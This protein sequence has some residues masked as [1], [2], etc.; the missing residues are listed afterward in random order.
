MIF[1]ILGLLLMF[2]SLSMLPPIIVSLIYQDLS[3]EPFIIGFL[4]VLLLGLILW[5]P[6]RK[7]Q[8]DLRIRDGFLI[9][10]LIWTV[11]GI[12][13]GVP[14]MLS[15]TPY[16]SFTDAVF[17]A[18]S[19]I[20]TTGATVMSDL[21]NLPQ[22]ILYYRQ[23]LQWL[24]GMGFIVLALAVLPLLG[25]G[26]MQ[27]YRAEVPGPM[28]ETKLTPR[29]TDTA[30]ALWGIYLGITVACIIAYWLA[31][32][33]LFDAIGHAFS[34][35]ATGGFS[36]H[37]QSFAYFNSPLIEVIGIFFM[38]I[39]GINFAVHFAALTKRNL[40]IYFLDSEVGAY[41]FIL[42]LASLLVCSHLIIYKGEEGVFK[43]FYEGTFQVVSFMTST[44]FSSAEFYNWP[45]FTPVLLI[46]VSFVG[47]CAGSTAGGLKVIRVLLLYKQGLREIGRLVHPSA[48][49]PVKIGGEPTSDRVTEAVWGFFALYVVSFLILMLLMMETGL[50]QVSA[51]SGVAACINN[52]GPGLGEVATSFATVSDPAKWVACVAMVLGRLEIFTVLV[53]LTPTYWRS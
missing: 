37:D 18:I 28:K 4:I 16:M 19:G 9:V 33:S 48:H 51:F 38:V 11:L 15:T 35:V 8:R 42:T 12:S 23:Q 45:S 24:G 20:T 44:G 1:K 30:K 32:M 29:I 7:F 39:A 34:T 14:L 22:S 50:D 31:G 27:L 53:L 2:F 5:F 21:D 46:F 52:L 6:F 43:S 47:G 41:L 25:V 17:E 49:I 36:T 3:I 10:V 26:G 40:K 13:G